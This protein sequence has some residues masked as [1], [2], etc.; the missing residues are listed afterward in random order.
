MTKMMMK[1]GIA[2]KLPIGQGASWQGG[3]SLWNGSLSQ[4]PMGSI[5]QL[6]TKLPDQ[7]TSQD[8][9]G[10]GNKTI[11]SSHETFLSKNTSVDSPFASRTEQVINS[12]LKNPVL[13][14]EE[15]EP[16]EVVCNE[17]VCL[18][19][20]STCFQRFFL[21]NIRTYSTVE[22]HFKILWLNFVSLH[23]SFN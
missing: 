16:N 10:Y 7:H 17:H 13:K 22:L 18:S 8:L 19:H 23:S 5:M 2:P 11:G 20:F 6:A 15:S 21:N 1:F 4:N 3:M 12:F 9:P 14:G